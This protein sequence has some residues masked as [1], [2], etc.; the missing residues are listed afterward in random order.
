MH[1]MHLYI[2]RCLAYVVFH[3][4]VLVRVCN[5]SRGTRQWSQICLVGEKLLT[6]RH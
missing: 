4:S 3:V 6:I 5:R 1:P 2:Y